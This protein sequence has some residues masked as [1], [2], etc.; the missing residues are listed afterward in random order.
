MNL[1]A[2]AK[3]VH[4]IAPSVKV[5]VHR[6][7]VRLTGELD[8]WDA[9]YRCGVAAVSGKSLGVLNDIR[10]KGFVEEMKKVLPAHAVPRRYIAVGKFKETSSG[11]II[12]KI[13]DN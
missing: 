11:K 4:K 10:L 5:E 1:K 12:R 2:I 7:C 13:F 9:I 8:S 6:G 3:R